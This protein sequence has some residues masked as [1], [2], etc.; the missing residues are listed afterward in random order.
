MRTLVYSVMFGAILA[1]S[2]INSEPVSAQKVQFLN[3]FK[4]Y[5]VLDSDGAKKKE[6]KLEDQFISTVGV[7][8]RPVMMCNPT[9]KNN[10]PIENKAY[11]LVCYELQTKE[12]VRKRKVL[13]ISQLDEVQIVTGKPQVFCL[14][15]EKKHL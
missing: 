14:P 6:L 7:I 5:N 4:C 15:V 10:E 13:T 2:G 1:L 3:H 9:E 12:K 8:G 11:H